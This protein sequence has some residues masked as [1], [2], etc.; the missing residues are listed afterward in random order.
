MKDILFVLKIFGFTLVLIILMQI[1][2]GTFTIE[3]RAALFIQ[4]SWLTTQVQGVASGLSKV[5]K[6]VTGELGQKVSGVFGANAPQKAT[7][8]QLNFERSN[9]YQGSQ[10]KKSTVESAKA[11][12]RSLTQ[13]ANDY[14]VNESDIQ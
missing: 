11:Q 5:L 4:D 13:E 3:E 1:K 14:Q 7:R 6:D 2:V 12:V 10:E 9:A 8:G